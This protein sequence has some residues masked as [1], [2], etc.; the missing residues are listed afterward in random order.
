MS[1]ISVITPTFNAAGTLGEA[2]QSAA[3]QLA[4]GEE[5][6]LI[7]ACSTDGTLA[8]AS[9]FPH[10]RILSEPDRGIYDAMNKGV[11]MTSGDWILFLQAD[12]WLPSG[13]L[14]AFRDSICANP[15]A[16]MICGSAGAVKRNG[17]SWESVW[18]VEDA[19]RK[20]LTFEN[21]ALGEPMINARLIRRDAFLSLGGFS[22]DYTLASDR[23]FLLRAVGAGIR[24]VEI[25]ATTYCYRWHSGS[26]TMT[27]GNAFTDTLS[28]ENLCIA[29]RHHARAR[30]NT[31]R[32]L[33]RWH[34]RL[35]VQAAMNSL[36]RFSGG[37]FIRSVVS[38]TRV[39]P[40]WTVR[41]LGV[42][43]SSLPGFVRRGFR[44]RTRMLASRSHA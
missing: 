36:E 25:P 28:R 19:V 37:G 1:R 9:R 23:D 15:G 35:T 44:T 7:D 22:P 39:D 13:S 32:I 12:D 27:E 42:L 41:F 38:G 34:T 33:S 30:G 26:S 18:F 16:A 6:L 40:V 31:R 17:A 4:P 24:Q 20:S 14:A 5:H 21:I 10:L 2:L 3:G 8:V 11:G 29:R 43:A